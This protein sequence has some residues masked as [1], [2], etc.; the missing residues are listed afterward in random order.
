MIADICFHNK[1]DGNPH[2]HI[3]LTV[4]PFNEDGSWEA[5]R[6]RFIF[7][8]GMAKRFM[9]KRNVSINV[10]RFLRL[11]GMKEAMLRSGERAGQICATH[12]LKNPDTMNE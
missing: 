8:M 5:S 10:N 3:M 7:S 1:K 6:K 9:T 2:A 12:I 4:R 11:T